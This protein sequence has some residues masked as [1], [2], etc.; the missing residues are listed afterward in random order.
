MLTNYLVNSI[1]VLQH[2]T[3][4]LPKFHAYIYQ[5]AIDLQTTPKIN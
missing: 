4:Y 2:H 3:V 1:T 5:K